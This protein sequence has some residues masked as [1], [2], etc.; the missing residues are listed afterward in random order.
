VVACFSGFAVASLV[1]ATGGAISCGCFGKVQVHPWFTF[2]LDTAVALGVWLL[3]RSHSLPLIRFRAPGGWLLPAAG[4]ASIALGGTLTIVMVGSP[5][6]TMRSDEGLILG[7]GSLIALKPE[8]WLGRKLPLLRYIES[9][10]Y[11]VD[12]MVG[13]WLVVLYQHDCSHCQ[14]L[15]PRVRAWAI[16]EP[17]ARVALVEVPPYAS[18]ADF[19]AG[20]PTSGQKRVVAGRLS[21]SHDWFVQTPTLIELQDG[22]VRRISHDF[23]ARSVVVRYQPQL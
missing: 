16:R 19:G 8:A 11:P 3:P 22:V 20:E 6:V 2:V 1:L 13:N 15:I 9:G 21:G 23:Q 5:S 10:S 14:G 12:V 18:P 7:R 4:A 17:E